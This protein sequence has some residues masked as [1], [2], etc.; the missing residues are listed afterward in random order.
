MTEI[1]PGNADRIREIFSDPAGNLIENDVSADKFHVAVGI[2]RNGRVFKQ[3]P[4][5]RRLGLTERLTHDIIADVITVEM[6][7]QKRIGFKAHKFL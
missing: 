5:L 1:F 4:Q 6:G 3:T 2:R 7:F